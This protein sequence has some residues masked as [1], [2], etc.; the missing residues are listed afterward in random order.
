MLHTL[1]C[2]VWC[3]LKTVGSWNAK[4]PAVEMQKCEQLKFKNASSWNAKMWAVEMQKC[5]Q[6]KCK[7]VSSWNAKLSWKWLLPRSLSCCVTA[8]VTD[9][10]TSSC[11]AHLTFY[12][13]YILHI[14]HFIH[15]TFL[16]IL[17]VEL[18]G[19]CAQRWCG[20]SIVTTI[21]TGGCVK[22]SVRCTW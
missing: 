8:P 1:K 14:L 22:I 6:L 9:S 15:F 18:Q 17:H 2:D 19:T 7:N 20:D 10:I 5:Q 11:N 3:K 16:Y 21:A 12:T 13:F 4:M